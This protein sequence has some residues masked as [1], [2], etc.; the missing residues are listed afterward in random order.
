VSVDGAGG[1]R[2]AA[3]GSTIRLFFALWPEPA[4]Q[5]TLAERA[6]SLVATAG[7]RAM[8]A[9]TLHVTLAFLGDVPVGLRPAIERAA[10]A[11]TFAPF[12]LVLDRTGWFGHRKLGWA[13]THAVPPA[14]ATLVATL[15]AALGANGVPLDPQP[16]VVHVT[17]VRNARTVPPGGPMT[18]VTWPVRDFALVASEPAAGGRVY[19][20]LRRWPSG[21]SARLE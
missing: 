14:L 5:S 4:L 2:P 18:P 11:A 19:R 15:R 3:S 9:E 21:E 13:G 12:D 16:F 6:R 7:G 20:V 17:L 8:R 1:P 10:G